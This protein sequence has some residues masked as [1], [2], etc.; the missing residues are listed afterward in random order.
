MQTQSD[1]IFLHKVS[2]GEF[3]DSVEWKARQLDPLSRKFQVESFIFI[4]YEVSFG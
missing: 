1:G 4:Q 2:S 3:I